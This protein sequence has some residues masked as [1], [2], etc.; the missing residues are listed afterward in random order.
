MTNEILR[1]PRV[2][3]LIGIGNTSLYAAI[4]RGDFPAPVK[5]GV[6][7]V[8]WRRSDIENWLASRETKVT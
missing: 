5:L 8:G 4:K 7:A 6:R 2:L 1:K 3:A